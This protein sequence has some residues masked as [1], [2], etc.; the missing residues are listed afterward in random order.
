MEKND[1]LVS[2]IM[3]SY[4]AARFI[5]ESIDSV[6]GQ[7]YGNWELLIV[8]DC[9]TDETMQTVAAYGDS[10]I[11]YLRNTTNCGA[12]VSRNRALCEARGR[13]IAFLDSDDLWLP[14]KLERQINFMIDNGYGFAYTDYTMRLPDGSDSGYVYTGPD[15]VSHGDLIKYC[16][17]STL[18]VIYDRATIGLLQIPDLKKHNDYAMWLEVSK[19]LD[20]YRLP[21]ALSIYRRR[22]GSI[23]NCSKANLIRHHYLLW[24]AFGHGPFGSVYLTF[25]NLIWGAYKKLKYRTPRDQRGV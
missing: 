5:G 24:R 22:D 23:S 18:T 6:L 16:W 2:I 25:G 3:P 9:S 17:L 10:R 19:T 21:E 8:D 13:W 14:Q 11:R 7:T 20:C 1:D 4:N 12:A 15:V